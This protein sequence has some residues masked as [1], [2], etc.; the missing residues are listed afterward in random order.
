M[1]IIMMC[2]RLRS[3]APERVLLCSNDDNDDDNADDNGDDD[4]DDNGD[5]D[6]NDDNDD[7]DDDKDD[8][9]DNDDWKGCGPLLAPAP[10]RVLLCSNG[11]NDDNDDNCDNDDHDDNDDNDAWKATITLVKLNAFGSRFLEF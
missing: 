2:G 3:P 11:D 5:D 8:D 9:D 4:D 10:E 7:N 1:M 6:D